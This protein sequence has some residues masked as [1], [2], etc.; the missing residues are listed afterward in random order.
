MQIEGKVSH[1]GLFFLGRGGREKDFIRYSIVLLTYIWGEFSY[2]QLSVVKLQIPRIL[3]NRN[4][5]QCTFQCNIS[6]IMK[7]I[8]Y[9]P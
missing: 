3:I 7:Q 9:I 8:E 1:F 5:L 6:L 4:I 2:C